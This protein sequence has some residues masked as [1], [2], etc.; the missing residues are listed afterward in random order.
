MKL[1]L[2]LSWIY[3]A[4]VAVHRRASAPDAVL[5]DTG[6]RVISVGNLEAGG[7]GKTPLAMWLLE[8][9]TARGLSSAYV[10]RG[11]GVGSVSAHAVT[12]VLPPACAPPSLAGKR[13][14][15]QSFPGLA[16]E[17]GDE[18]ALVV[19]RAPASAAF[20]CRDKPRALR[21]ALELGVDRV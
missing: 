3:G 5:P 21:A 16:S 7:N 18:G 20:F 6:T 14:L 12:C 9:W 15:A 19:D 1:L 10:S 17:V 11:Y 8:H 13:I 2:P 4:G